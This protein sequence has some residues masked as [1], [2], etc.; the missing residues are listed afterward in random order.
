MTTHKLRIDVQE[1]ASCIQKIRDE[2]VLIEYIFQ[3]SLIKECKDGDNMD[4][5]VDGVGRRDDC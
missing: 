2:L 3:Q 5:G 1:I 4:K